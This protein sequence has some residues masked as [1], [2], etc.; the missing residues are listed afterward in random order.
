LRVLLLA[1]QADG[2]PDTEQLL[3]DTLDFSLCA[4][5]HSLA[6]ALEALHVERPDV[7]ITDM[8]LAD[9]DAFELLRR[10]CNQQPGVRVLVLSVRH[11]ALCAERLLRAGAL[12]YVMRSAP[13]EE[14]RRATR[15]VAA[16]EMHISATLGM[17]FQRRFVHPDVNALRT[18]GCA[19]EVLSTREYQ[20]FQ[21]MG[22]GM[23]QTEICTALGVSVKTV[24]SHR[25][26]IRDKLSLV[27]VTQFAR[28]ALECAKHCRLE[29]GEGATCELDPRH[30]PLPGRTG[31]GLG[32]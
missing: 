23:T 10:V 8:V 21:L 27:G 32:T 9:G 16:G 14:V 15:R 13:G 2:E 6:A 7:V 26:H 28:C 19:L 3:R 31:F 17:E 20:I 29:R 30:R 5:C 24:E 25:Q 11:E 4:R 22:N 1:P 18:P 12:G